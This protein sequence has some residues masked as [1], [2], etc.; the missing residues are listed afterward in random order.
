MVK[1][2]KQGDGE[3]RFD[4]IGTTCTTRTSKP[5]PPASPRGLFG[6]YLPLASLCVIPPLAQ[7][8]WMG[9]RTEELQIDQGTL[10]N[11]SGRLLR[12]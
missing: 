7:K 5:L 12:Y 1:R 9:L 2:T 6:H 8:C 4:A 11:N 3:E 10:I